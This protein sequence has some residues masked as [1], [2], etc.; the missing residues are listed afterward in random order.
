MKIIESY[1]YTLNQIESITFDKIEAE[2]ETELIFTSNLFKKYFGQ[3]LKKEEVF[4][5]FSH[6]ELKKNT[7]LNLNEIIKERSK[8][9]PIQY[10]LD[11]AWFYG[12]NF[13]VYINDSHKALIPRNETELI[14]EKL[15]EHSKEKSKYIGIDIGTGT[16]CIPISFILN[17]SNDVFFDAIDP[18]TF[19]IAKKN[20]SKFKLEKKITLH[21]IGIEEILNNF[22]KKYDIITANLPYIPEDKK[23]KELVFEPKEALY[24]K[25]NG[26]HY[27]KI[28]FNILPDIIKNDGVALIEI[29][30]K[31]TDYLKKLKN[32]EISTFKDLNNLDRIAIIKLK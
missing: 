23:I 5:K 21:N 26:L 10:I 15:T 6:N 22:K 1:I 32:F 24:A 17:S 31:H 2:A 18:Y 4:G 14:V 13:H 7:L 27:I 20:I 12:H 28:F 9:I 16:C 11:E 30:P 19:K 3:S 29:D 8:G 25:D